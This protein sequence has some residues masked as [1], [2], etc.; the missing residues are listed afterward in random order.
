MDQIDNVCSKLRLEELDNFQPLKDLTVNLGVKPRH[1]GLVA[2]VLIGIFAIVGYGGLWLSFLV[3]FLYPAYKSFKA[4]ETTNDDEDDKQWLTYW[5]I[6]GFMHCFQRFLNIVLD[7]IP[8]SAVLKLAFNIWLFHPSTKGAT[9][10]YNNFFKGVLK[11]YEGMIDE[12]L[13][14]I[15]KT[16]SDT[17]PMLDRAA[18]D[19]KREAVNRAIN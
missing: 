13:E 2:V 11:K 10:L 14:T 7:L 15:G 19:L 8:F 6:F 4:L 5:V 9:V 17:A 18:R 1:V 16:V 3:G 12:H